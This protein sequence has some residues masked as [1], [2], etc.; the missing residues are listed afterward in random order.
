MKSLDYINK[1]D[2]LKHMN[3]DS[4]ETANVYANSIVAANTN[5]AYAAIK[6]WFPTYYFA[7]FF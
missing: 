3:A 4:P 7:S 5:L 1:K 6:Q 2:F